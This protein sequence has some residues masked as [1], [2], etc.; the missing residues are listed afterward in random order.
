MIFSAV[1]RVKGMVPLRP[2]A[3]IEYSIKALAQSINSNFMVPY[4]LVLTGAGSSKIPPVVRNT[5]KSDLLPLICPKPV[6]HR[7]L[8]SPSVDAL[9]GLGF[10]SKVKKPTKILP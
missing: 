2:A 10:T 7:W 5:C 1:G 3:G 8:P 6:N 4:S 9:S